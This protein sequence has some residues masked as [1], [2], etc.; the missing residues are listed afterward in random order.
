MRLNLYSATCVFMATLGQAVTFEPTSGEMVS[1]WNN[2]FA[3]IESYNELSPVIRKNTPKP[4]AAAKA[5][6]EKARVAAAM[7]K[8][9][10]I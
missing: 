1:D 3:E 7:Q 6:A 5:A 2:A 10:N 9:K 4:T 8:A